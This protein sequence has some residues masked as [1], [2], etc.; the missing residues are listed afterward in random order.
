MADQREMGKLRTESGKL[1]AG[2]S[3]GSRERGGVEALKR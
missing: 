3:G 2:K 1:K